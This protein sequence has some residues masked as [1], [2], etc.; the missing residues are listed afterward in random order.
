MSC[1]TSFEPFSVNNA[2][3]CERRG[4]ILE[5]VLNRPSGRNSMTSELLSD[6][7]AAS[8]FVAKACQS[9][10]APRCVIVRGTG[11]CF[12]AGADFN[13]SLQ[14]GSGLPSERSF[15]MYK[16]FLSLLDIPVPIVGALNGHAVGG[17]FGLSLMCDL[18]VANKTAKYGANFV[19]LSFHPGMAISYVLPR[20]VGVA[21]ANELL[22]TGRLFSGDEGLQMGLFNDAV[23]E[24]DVLERARAF[25]DDIAQA[26]PLAV[27]TTKAALR[28]GLA[29]EVERAARAEAAL[30]AQSLQTADAKEGMA[31]ILEKR[32]P[33]F[34]GE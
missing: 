13:A 28:D 30:Q 34:R 24:G 25:A 26:G 32:A 1:E 27:R 5:I 29:W 9:E 8:V 6:F 18:R 2:V 10:D 16:P 15:A 12:S 20:L 21:K 7:H 4:H 33:E 14:V 3:Y 22:L 23:D 19:R 31:A 11:R 17:G